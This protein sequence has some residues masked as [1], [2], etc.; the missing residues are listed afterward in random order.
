MPIDSRIVVATAEPA[1]ASDFPFQR[2]M[3]TGNTVRPI[4]VVLPGFDLF[5]NLLLGK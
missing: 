3:N 4:T 2:D 1:F 5:I